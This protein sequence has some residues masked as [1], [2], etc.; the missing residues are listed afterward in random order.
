MASCQKL[1]NGKWSVSFYCKDYQG[2]NKKYKKMGFNTKKEALNYANDFINLH[3]GSNKTLL[4][5]VVN[6]FFD[7]HK[8]TIKYNTIKSYENLIK[9]INNTLGNYPIT[10][11][12]AKE[13]NFLFSK[14]VDKTAT[15]KH[16]KRFLNQVF[17]YAKLYYNLQ[18]NPLDN[19]LLKAKKQD[20]KEKEILTLEDFKDFYNKVL[21][22]RKLHVQAFFM[23][24]YF[25][26]ARCGEITALTLKDIDLINNTI[27]IN[28]TRVTNQKTNSPKNKSS[29]RVVTV[30]NQA[31]ETLKKYINTL[32]Y[33]PN[34][35]I[36]KTKEIYTDFLKYYKNKKVIK[37]GLTLHSFRHSHASYLI[38][39]GVDIAT[40]SK[41]LGHADVYV[42]MKT[43]AHFYDDKQDKILNLLNEINI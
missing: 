18:I 33:I 25:T 26:G 37:S 27:S 23:L 31:M 6:A 34:D 16:L 36:F 13:L 3:T 42:T 21:I 17:K 1:K 28:K 14:F 8:K 29:V 9:I 19:Y 38:K 22:K 40:I 32:P 41:R 30:P 10:D 11:I 43:Y 35:F 4:K 2:I 20:K 15:Q 7:E 39:N 12:Q 5:N 24:L